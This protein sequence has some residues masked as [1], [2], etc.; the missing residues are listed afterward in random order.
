[1]RRRARVA[2]ALEGPLAAWTIV[3][4]SVRY[5]LAL[6]ADEVHL[7]E[8]DRAQGDVAHV[9]TTSAN[10]RSMRLK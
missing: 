1:M 6:A 10:T 8:A 4:R 5:C 9:Y 7:A 2:Q 3:S